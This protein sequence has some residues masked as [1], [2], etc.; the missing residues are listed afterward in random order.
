MLKT[1][2]LTILL[3]NMNEGLVVLDRDMNILVINSSAAKFFDAGGRYE[4]AEC[5]APYPYA[6]NCRYAVRM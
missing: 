6:V 1:S 2:A 4:G 3:N 5:A